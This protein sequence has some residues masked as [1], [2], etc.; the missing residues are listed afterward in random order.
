MTTLTY[1]D[2]RLLVLV[3]GLI[4]A[5]GASA[6]LT[7]GRQED[8][9]ITNLFATIVTPFPGADPARVEALVTEPIERELLEIAE[10]DTIS[11]SSRRGLSVITVELSSFLADDELPAAWSEIRDALADVA[12]E[13]PAGVPEPEFE[14]DR[15]G[16]FTLIAAVRAAP[17]LEAAPYL[18]VR[19]AERLQDRLRTVPETKLV[20]LY[21][22]AEEEVLV[23]VDVERLAGFG[24]SPEAVAARLRAADAKVAAGTVHGPGT[25]LLV[26]VAGEIDALERIRSVPLLTDA[27]GTT[28]RVGDVATVG[29]AVTTPQE[30]LAIVDGAP[31]VLVA[32]RME[33]DRQVDTWTEAAMAAVD[34]YA[35]TLPAG[36]RVEVIFDQST[37]TADRFIELGRNM[38][39]GVSIVVL[40]LLATLG[41]RSALVVALVLP[42]SALVSIAVMQ[43]LGVPLHQ[44]SVT[45]LIVALGLL[46]DAA[47]VMTD[48]VRRRIASG[49]GRER[50]VGAGVARL[51]VPLLASTVTTILAFLPMALLPGPAG[52]FV[53]SIATAVIVMLTA[54]FVLALVVTP[55]FAGLLLPADDPGGGLAAGAVGRLFARL[56]RRG[57]ERPVA[58]LA[59]ALVL[60][61]MGF[62][63]FP[64][65]TAQFFPGVDRDQFH[66]QVRLGPA[67]S[68]DATH[69]L[70]L[71][72]DALLAEEPRIRRVDWVVGESAPAFYYNMQAN[73]DGVARFA[74][75]LVTTAGP[76]A[77]RA[78][79]AELQPLLDARFPEA[80]ILVRGLKQGPPV[81]A[82]VE[83]RLYGPDITTLDRLGEELRAIMTTVATVTHTR[84]SLGSAAPQLRLEVDETALDLLGLDPVLVARQLDA[85]LEGAVGGSLVEG[86][87]ELPV[88]VRLAGD[89][90]SA[91]A[92]VR[93]LVLVPAGADAASGFPG[94]PASAVATLTLVPGEPVITRRQGERVNTVQAFIRADVLPEEALQAVEAAVVASG[95]TVPEGYRIGLGGDSDARSETT[96]NLTASLGLI[97]ALT[98]ATIVLTFRSYRLSLITAGVAVLSVGLAVLALAVTGHP[99]GIQAL[100]GVIGSI[101][102]SINAAIIVLTA[103]RDT[104]EARAGEVEAITA[105]VLRSSR[106][107]WSTTLTTFGGFLP[108]I[109]A[110]GGFWPP[111]AT[112]I[113]GGVLLSVVLA[114]AFTPAL[115]TLVYA[116]RPVPAARALR[117]RDAG[118]ALSRPEP[119]LEAADALRP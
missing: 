18:L 107:I 31:A 89:R 98:V 119:R 51:A 69:G 10:I 13:L 46:V 5:T 60:P 87:E 3:V 12:L 24:L 64:T 73:E 6:L 32:A 109:L 83:L 28:L 104:P 36:L 21:G 112:A 76:D 90:R 37:Y 106:H 82:P 84:A 47:I 71:E 19:E 111:F 85:A 65:L 11:S 53:G 78:L 75:G 57:I 96:R 81:D 14:N 48:E 108:L 15:T 59:V 77:T 68:I 25:R 72:L 110:G 39:A 35:A 91:V 101:G 45:G 62:L 54:S 114:F 70:A 30:S 52:D 49:I 74:E 118:P 1:R 41:W 43:R 38:A 50:A 17:G 23:A 7:I 94:V 9:T 100:I 56:V 55:A 86:S 27:A 115:F 42:L 93:D 63:A 20:D 97:G 26:E 113:A 61:L 44:M 92:T 88:R 105:V 117:D 34:A 67:T 66:V 58:A 95:W 2:L 8:P 80:Q 29:R 99:F 22:A 40:V 33:D 79:L 16:A 4:L 116:R 103:L 102:V